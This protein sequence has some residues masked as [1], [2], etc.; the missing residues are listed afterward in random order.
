MRLRECE[1]IILFMNVCHATWTGFRGIQVKSQKQMEMFV[2]LSHQ[3]KYCMHSNNHFLDHTVQKKRKR[4]KSLK[5]KCM[6]QSYSEICHWISHAL[7]FPLCS[8]VPQASLFSQWEEKSL[9]AFP[10]Q[11]AAQSLPNLVLLSWK[12]PSHA[13]LF[14]CSRMKD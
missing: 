2:F 6:H 9:S 14:E 4:L 12:W 8:F 3:G 13:R 5:L 10:N 7:L 11:G 1:F